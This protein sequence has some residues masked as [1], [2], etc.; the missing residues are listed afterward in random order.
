MTEIR[1]YH[2][3]YQALEQALPA[4]LNKALGT[5]KRIVVKASDK[6][7][8]KALNEQLW[9]YRPDS[10]LPHGSADDGFSSDQ[11]VYLTYEDENPNGAAVLILTD[12]AKSA[13]MDQFDLCC[14]MLNGRD[15][16]QVKAARGRWKA[17]QE[18]G[19][20]I[21]YWQQSDTGGWEKKA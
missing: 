10:F 3:Q 7:R 15:D 14:E 11:P 19:H 12:G 17:Y 21:T 1:F 6:A 8:V 5:G 2:L 13:I 9:T 20:D 4:L 16:A 18:A